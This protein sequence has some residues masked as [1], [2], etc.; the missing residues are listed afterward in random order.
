MTVAASPLRPAR[1]VAA[2]LVFAA[3]MAGIVLGRS[4][5]GGADP[6]TAGATPNLAAA[7]G[8]LTNGANLVDGTHYEPFGAGFTDIG[9]T[10]DGALGLAAAGTDNSALANVTNYV[11][12]NAN[13]WTGIGTPDVSGGSVGKE[14][15]L[16]E[17][18]GDDPRSFGGNDLI[19]ALDQSVCSGASTPPATAC[20]AAGT[21][22]NSAST[23]NQALG[24]IAQLRAGDSV[25]AQSP[26]SYL[27]SQQQLS[28]AWP[29][30]IPS[31]GDSDVDSTAMAVMALDLVPGAS[32]SAAVHQGIA[33]VASQ[34]E[35]DGGFPGVSGDN[36]N[37]A[38][39]AIMAMDLEPT[40]FVAQI[41]A[42]LAFLAAEQ[43]PDGGFNIS[44]SPGSQLGSDLRASAQAVNGAV[45]T[46]FGT[47]AD[48]LGPTPP[49]GPGHG[50]WEVAADGGIF[51]FG[52]AGYFGS[53]GGT[54][55]NQPVVGM[56]SPAS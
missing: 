30:L 7:V 14:A 51:S 56:V 27:E 26:I 4:A 32:A 37:S 3:T 38:A 23:F 28:G 1:V 16:A 49:A 19:A 20:L 55:L 41:S 12:A 44:S 36:T 10:L 46:S 47:L 42:G 6:L 24:V 34:Q 45:G 29:S 18:V 11:A 52:D 48:P 8:Y 53:M 9:L 25:N 13:S 2:L 33:W 31:T 54:R 40:A 21:Y 17:V 22:E 35:L 50:Y 15:L 43:N 5:A 39:L